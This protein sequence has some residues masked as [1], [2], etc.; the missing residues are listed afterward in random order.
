MCKKGILLQG[1]IH[2]VCGC[3]QQILENTLRKRMAN[4]LFLAFHMSK[5]HAK[6]I[7]LGSGL[8]IMNIVQNLTV[9]HIFK[10]LLSYHCNGFYHQPQIPL[11]P[12]NPWLIGITSISSA[13]STQPPV[14]HDS[15]LICPFGHFLCMGSYITLFLVTFFFGFEYYA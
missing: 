8:Y 5:T 6:F 2:I 1:N 7:F 4:C 15:C 3:W 10:E 14:Y 13:N 11:S 9:F 12:K